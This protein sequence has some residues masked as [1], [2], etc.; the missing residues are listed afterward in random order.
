LALET[1]LGTT[2]KTLIGASKNTYEIDDKNR[3]EEQFISSQS[4]HR[5]PGE[6]IWEITTKEQFEPSTFNLLIW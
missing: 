2:V 5:T 3:I 4:F 6:R 1:G